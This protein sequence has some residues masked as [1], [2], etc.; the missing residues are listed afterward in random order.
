METNTPSKRPS[1]FRQLL[2]AVGGAAIALVLY[3][4][5][6]VG[7]PVVTAWLVAP[8]SQIAAEHPGTARANR[9]VSEYEFS[10]LTAKAQEIYKRFA[11]EPGPQAEISR[12]GIEVTQPITASS[13]SI[14]HV[15]LA[16]LTAQSSASSLAAS[17]SAS[18]EAAVSSV[19]SIS[20]IAVEPVVEPVV[21]DAASSARARA[22]MQLQAKLAGK[23]LPSSGIGT[24]L[25]A[26]VAFGT[27]TLLRK[28]RSSR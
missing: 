21:A 6:K 1:L 10:R 17:S 2:G 8:Q 3:Q 18:S 4:A 12:T 13:S 7:S 22:E 15:D 14:A 19:S 16:D 9:E 26:A 28:K 20:S 11:A 23:N 27:A 25:V 5:Y 24:S